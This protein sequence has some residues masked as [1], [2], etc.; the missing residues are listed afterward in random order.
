MCA[1]LT[2]ELV[3]DSHLSIEVIRGAFQEGVKLRRARQILDHAP[4]KHARHQSLCVV[5]LGDFI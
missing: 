3:A 2:V 4:Q 1:S 5:E